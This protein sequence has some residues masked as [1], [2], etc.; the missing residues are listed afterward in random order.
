MSFLFSDRSRLVEAFRGKR[1]ALVGSGPGSLDNP[2]GFVDSHDVVV[3]VNN[4]RC[5][6]GTGTGLRTDVHYSFYGNSIK[7]SAE[8]LKRDGVRLCIAKC[9]DDQFMESA[10]HRRRGKMTGVDFRYIYR[11]RAAF[12]FCPTYVPPTEEF[13]ESFELLQRHI[14]TTGFAAVLQVLSCEPANVFITGMDFFQTQVHNVNERWKAGDPADPIGHRA[15]LE[16]A[17]FIDNVERLPIT[18]DALLSQAVSGHVAS[19]ITPSKP[20]RKIRFGPKV[21]AA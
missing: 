19:R 15:D 13:M 7:K 11:N 1:I 10:W 20:I 6:P 21:R 16:R 3:R 12:W 8:E 9:P 18:M 17:W 14:P 2:Q 5:I 4:Y